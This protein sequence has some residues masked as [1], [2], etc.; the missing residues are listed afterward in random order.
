MSPGR[1]PSDPSRLLL[2]I[3]VV[4]VGLNL[5]PFLAGI[6]PLAAQIQ[7]ATGLAYQSMSLFTLVPMALMGLCA[8]AGPWLQRVMGA[9]G[10]VVGA[11][12]LLCLASA[13]RLVIEDGYALIA[14]AALCGLGVAVV[15]S[16]FPGIIKAHFPS[17]VAIVM[18]LY[19]AMLMG[20]GRARR[21]GFADHRGPR[22]ELACRPRLDRRAGGP[23]AALA[24]A[25]ALPRDRSSQPGALRVGLLLR[26]PRTWLLMACFGL[27]NGGYSSIIAWLAPYYQALGWTGAASGT[28]LAIMAASQAVAALAM[29]ILAARRRDRRLWICLS[30]G[31][32]VAGFAGLAFWPGLLPVGW[33]MLV[34][35]GLGGSFA[36]SMI[37]ALDHLEN[38]ADAGALSA[39]MQG[40]RL[41]A[42]RPATLDHGGAA[43][44]DRQLCR[45]LAD[46]SGLRGTGRAPVP[47]LRP[48]WLC[49]VDEASGR[50]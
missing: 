41:P 23:L 24:A 27:V 34:G 13:A 48:A 45:R 16:V 22:R 29:P 5:R 18:G 32:Q 46:A 7:R 19:S 33:T 37:V 17:R 9:R 1:H 26:R 8:F 11:L 49:A 14:T 38:P 44:P 21:T 50:S 36:L 6:G 31:F 40:R 39:L 4:L 3:A 42:R 47:A 15:Q 2:L 25:I 20:G 10:A 28:L 30:L 35:A 43:R 12:T